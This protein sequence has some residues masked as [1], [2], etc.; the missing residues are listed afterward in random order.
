MDTYQIL[1]GVALTLVTTLG[2]W[3][4][5]M[6]WSKIEELKKENEKLR[7]QLQKVKD[8]EKDENDKLRDFFDKKVETLHIRINDQEK[9]TT[10]ELR[11]QMKKSSDLEVTLTGFQGNFITREEHRQV[12]VQAWA[13]ARAQSAAGGQGGP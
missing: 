2:G 6:V 11:E 12:C 13:Q 9:A 7:E 10:K 8:Y 4:F 5:K 3:V 1:F